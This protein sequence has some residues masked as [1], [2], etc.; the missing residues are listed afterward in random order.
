MNYETNTQAIEH[1]IQKIALAIQH[2]K[3]GQVEIEDKL[4]HNSQLAHSGSYRILVSGQDANKNNEILFRRYGEQGDKTTLTFQEL[5]YGSSSKQAGSGGV[6]GI[7]NTKEL[8]TEQKPYSYLNFENTRMRII[9]EISRLTGLS[10]KEIIGEIHKIDKDIA[11]NQ[12][13]TPH[14]NAEISALEI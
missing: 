2:L 12:H 3:P 7:Y 13:S 11:N 6:A 8:E 9:D 4:N 1:Y 10:S 5:D 14:T